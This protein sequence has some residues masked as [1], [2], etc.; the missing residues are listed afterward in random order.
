MKTSKKFILMI[1]LAVLA[2]SLGACSGRRIL[3]TGWAGVTVAE[4]TVYFSYGPQ[5]FALNL[6]NGSQI[7]Q[8]PAE[9]IKGADFYAAPV[10]ADEGSQLI[11]A[12]YNSIL[13]SIDPVTAVEKW[14]F[15]GASGRYIATPLVT[16]QGIFA[17]SADNSLYALDFDGNLLWSFQTGDPLWASP[18]WSESCGCIY[19]ASMDHRLYALD[20]ETGELRWKTDDLGGPIVSSPALSEDGLIIVSTFNNEVLAFDEGTREIAWRFNTSDWSWASPVIDGLKVYASDISGIFYALDLDTGE[21]LWQLQP[22]GGI[23]SA[24]LVQDGMIYISTDA[25]SLVVANSDGVTQRNQPIEG[26]LYAGPIAAGDNLLLAPTD[27][28]YYLVA[29]NTSGVQVWGFPPPK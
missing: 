17:P 4:D 9:P 15:E 23:Y 27:A 20:A 6:K 10:L 24:P 25:S 5:A 28:E 12:S 7:W 1:L 13:Y 11:V 14:S 16:E 19:Q 29:Y 2:L 26:K 18:A 3:A 21:L 22:G 8:F